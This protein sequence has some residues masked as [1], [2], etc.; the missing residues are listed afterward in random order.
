MQNGK[1]MWIKY[2]TMLEL[3]KEEKKKVKKSPREK[4]TNVGKS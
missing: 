3:V 1:E 4:R 2:L